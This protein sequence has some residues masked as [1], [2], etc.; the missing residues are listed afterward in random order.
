MVLIDRI[1]EI[2][3]PILCAAAPEGG[4]GE[5][6]EPDDAAVDTEIARALTAAEGHGEGEDGSEA[7]IRKSQLMLS[8]SWRG[9]KEAAALLGRLVSTS[10][11]QDPEVSQALW[12][13]IEIEQVGRRFDLWMTAVRH[14]GAFSTIYPAYSIASGAIRRC[15]W[16]AIK[17][18]N[19]GQEADIEAEYQELEDL[20][21]S[22][23]VANL[24]SDERNTLSSDPNAPMDAVVDPS[25][26]TVQ[27][28]SKT[29]FHFAKYSG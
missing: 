24:E 6:L 2:T 11:R 20:Y 9:M 15:K 17:D 22:T 8:Y 3:Q 19:E 10:L 12:T 4:V 27:T 21:E 14:R 7:L 29:S 28:N 16:P 18:K 26:Q 25:K 13:V 1:W 5:G 23:M